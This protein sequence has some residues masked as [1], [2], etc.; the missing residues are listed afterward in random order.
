VFG[1]KSATPTAPAADETSIMPAENTG[2]GRPT[3]T[4]KEAE[5]ARLAKARTPRTRK[6]AAAAERARRT[7]ANG[8]MRDAMR[9]GDDRYLP[10]RDKGPVRRFVR[11]YV[12]SK[13]T[14]AEFILPL[15]VVTMV[16]GWVG[17]SSMIAFANTFMLL[18]LLATAGNLVLIVVGMRRQV[19]KRWPDMTTR[20]LGYYACVRVLQLRVLRMPKPQVKIGDK[21]GDYR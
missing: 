15:L 6:E 7:D 5:A 9:T 16:L 17:G 20:G 19:K 14:V 3:P 18:L 21:L 10:T 2:K 11:D 8:K 12:D 13:F 1:R 4:R